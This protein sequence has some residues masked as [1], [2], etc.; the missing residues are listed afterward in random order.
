MQDGRSLRRTRGTRL[1]TLAASLVLV[2]GACGKNDDAAPEDASA[3]ISV[4]ASFFPLAEVARAVGGDLVQVSNLTRA[5]TEPHDL[6]LTASQ[7]DQLEDADLVLYL[8]QGFQPAVAEVV[9]RRSGRRVD[10]LEVIEPG[11]GELDDHDDAPSEGEV[12]APDEEPTAG[13]HEHPEGGMDPHFWLDPT[14]LAR[15]VDRVEAALAEASP[16]QAG[17]FAANADR[18][19]ESLAELDAEFEQGLADCDRRDLVTS[20]AAFHYL[21]E[22]YGLRQLPIAGLSPESEPG[23]DRMAELADLITEVGVTTVFYETLAAPD[24]AETLAREAGVEVAVLNPLEGLT[25]AEID[26]GKDYAAVMGDNLA[27][28]TKALGCR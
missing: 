21:A 6:E 22:R 7:V 24:V 4:V 18:Y 15:A 25:Q 1:L 19:Q 2:A 5:G 28:L 12:Q 20:H 3:P 10:L 27:A 14:L 11:E 9:E 13:G 26:A 17:A 16:D 8:G 23:P